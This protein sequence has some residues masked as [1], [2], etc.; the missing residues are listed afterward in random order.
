MKI[1]EKK[2]KVLSKKAKNQTDLPEM[3]NIVTNIKWVI[4]R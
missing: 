2:S 1:E 3:K 4:D